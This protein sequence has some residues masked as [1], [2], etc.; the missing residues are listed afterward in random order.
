MAHAYTS[1]NQAFYWFKREWDTFTAYIL[2][3]ETASYASATAFVGG[4]DH[5][6]LSHLINSTQGIIYAVK[7]I[8]DYD[9]GDPDQSYFFESIYWASRSGLDADPVEVTMDDLINTMLTAD[10]AQVEYFIGLVDAYRQS[11]W[12]RPFNQEFFAALGRGFATWA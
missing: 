5:L 4:D 8:I 9:S 6:A 10:P 11:L 7:D 1:F 2:A 12:T 3:A